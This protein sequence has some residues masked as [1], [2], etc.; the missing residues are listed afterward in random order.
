MLN[1]KRNHSPTHMHKLFICEY[2]TLGRSK[3]NL[4]IYLLGHIPTLHFPQVASAVHAP[5][6][7]AIRVAV[8]AGGDVGVFGGRPVR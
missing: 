5:A 8:C 2:D 4:C 3:P 6:S 1:L 7:L